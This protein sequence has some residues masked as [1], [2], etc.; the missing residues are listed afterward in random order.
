MLQPQMQSQSNGVTLKS[1]IGFALQSSMFRL[2]SRLYYCS[3]KKIDLTHL[4]GAFFSIKIQTYYL[5][6][7]KGENT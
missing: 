5:K 3:Y 4:I 6:Y 1:R 7:K 2:R